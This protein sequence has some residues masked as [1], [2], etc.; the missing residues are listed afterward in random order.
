MFVIKIVMDRETYLIAQNFRLFRKNKI[1]VWKI[2]L[3]IW[4]SM[5]MH[6]YLDVQTIYIIIMVNV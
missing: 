2:A 6:V 1:Y 5:K 3:S 4:L